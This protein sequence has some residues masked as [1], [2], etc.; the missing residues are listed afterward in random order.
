MNVHGSGFHCYSMVS[1][2]A[3]MFHNLGMHS[4]KLRGKVGQAGTYDDCSSDRLVTWAVS[5][6]VAA[7]CRL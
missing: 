4:R 7:Q 2:S 1:P 6:A 5:L 3:Q